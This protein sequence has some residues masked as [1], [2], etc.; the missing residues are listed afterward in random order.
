MLNEKVQSGKESGRQEYPQSS[1]ENFSKEGEFV[2]AA[3]KL[4]RVRT[5]EC[6]ISD[7]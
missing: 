7:L 5:K 4:L 3:E 1:S 2:V 6:I